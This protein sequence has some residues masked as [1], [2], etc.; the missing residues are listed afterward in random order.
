M[1]R[2]QGLYSTVNPDRINP[3]FIGIGEKLS[4]HKRNRVGSDKHRK[5]I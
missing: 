4:E 5:N 3:E 1:S 2:I